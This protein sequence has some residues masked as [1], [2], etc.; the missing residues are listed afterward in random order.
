MLQEAL[1]LRKPRYDHEH[2]IIV[3]VDTSPIG[4]GWAISQEEE[5][6]SR[7]GIR[8]GAKVLIERQRV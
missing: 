4:I 5:D 1:V 2:S 8:F 3:T 7:Y 6:G